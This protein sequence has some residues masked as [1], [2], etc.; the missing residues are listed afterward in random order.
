MQE[1]V[2]GLERDVEGK[3]GVIGKMGQEIDELK[4]IAGDANRLKEEGE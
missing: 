4:V 3:K 2:T 1:K